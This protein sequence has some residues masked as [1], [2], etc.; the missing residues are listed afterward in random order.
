MAIVRKPGTVVIVTLAFTFVTASIVFLSASKPGSADVSQSAVAYNPEQHNL[1][2][3]SGS[4]SNVSGSAERTLLGQTYILDVAAVLPS[5]A[6]D[7]SY[8]VWLADGPDASA[9]MVNI[10]MLV[11]HDTK[12]TLTYTSSTNYANYSYVQISQEKGA[13][14]APSSNVLHGQFTKVQEE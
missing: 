7:A 2:A 14:S 6:S 4:T 3:L 8:V 10:G 1:I 9:A 5:V 12:Y 13:S 11:K